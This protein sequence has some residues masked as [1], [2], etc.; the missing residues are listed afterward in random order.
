MSS[1]NRVKS[2]DLRV[3]VP[4]IP[5]A[6]AHNAASR[7][8]SPCA[9]PRIIK[10]TKTDSDGEETLSDDSKPDIMDCYLKDLDFCVI[11]YN[12][13]PL[14]MSEKFTHNDMENFCCPNAR[15]IIYSTSICTKGVFYRGFVENE[16]CY[17][18][19][20]ARTLRAWRSQREKNIPIPEESIIVEDVMS[21]KCKKVYLTISYHAICRDLMI[22]S[23][24]CCM[25]TLV[26]QSVQVNCRLL[27]TG[28][29]L[30]L[31]LIAIMPALNYNKEGTL[32]IQ[33][34][35]QL[36]KKI[37]CSSERIALDVVRFEGP[38]STE[39]AIKLKD[40]TI[41]SSWDEEVDMFQL[42]TDTS[43]QKV[44]EF[45]DDLI[46]R[47]NA[48]LF[49]YSEEKSSLSAQLILT[50]EIVA[51]VKTSL[52]ECGGYQDALEQVDQEIPIT[53]NTYIS[54]PTG[55]VTNTVF[56][57]SHRMLGHFLT[58]MGSKHKHAIKILS[59]N[60]NICEEPRIRFMYEVLV[61]KNVRLFNAKLIEI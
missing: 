16:L 41:H 49:I 28:T 37:K 61:S 20:Y 45:T 32:E 55:T 44:L 25:F 59:E 35:E 5:C 3:V 19:D 39:D 58:L 52:K 7:D 4:R 6:E 33:L 31:G 47:S 22:N 54:S 36:R 38:I 12:I 43:Y 56:P 15:N 26:D 13:V 60:K 2:N 50:K 8:S 9:S 27:V 46:V 30:S 23:I 17:I 51:F 57:H 1:S 34:H 10:K 14:E 11:S 29:A 18:Y 21:E 48:R 42:S 53:I 24:R 40:Y